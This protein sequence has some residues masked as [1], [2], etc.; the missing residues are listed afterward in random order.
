M[1]NLYKDKSKL[2][3]CTI[4]TNGVDVNSLKPRFCIE[5]NNK[6]SYFFNGQLDSSGKCTVDIPKFKDILKEN[7]N[8]S[9]GKV[10]LELIG[11]DI[12]SRPWEEE[13][14][15]ETYNKVEVKQIKET[16]EPV[17]EKK[18]KIVAEVKKE[19]PKKVV[20]ETI[21]PVADLAGQKKYI[22]ESFKKLK[23]LDQLN[24]NTI[25]III[26]ES[27]KK[28]NTTPDQTEKL[29]KSILK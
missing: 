15:L 26:E 9:S 4:S 7:D 1:F 17:V 6:V 29:L 18:P 16:V 14:S 2:F 11:E 10:Y 8:L 24:K 20:V 19:E 5:G 12:Y 21:K 23:E 3:E 13:F 25:N 28:Y 27:V 22:I